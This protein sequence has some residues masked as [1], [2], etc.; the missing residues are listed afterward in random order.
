VALESSA[1]VV[2]SHPS[3]ANTSLALLQRAQSR[4]TATPV[5]EAKN[6]SRGSSSQAKPPHQ[7]HAAFQQHHSMLSI[8]RHAV[9]GEASPPEG[10][11]RDDLKPHVKSEIGWLEAIWINSGVVGIAL[12]AIEGAAMSA[13]EGTCL[14]VII[15]SCLILTVRW[16]VAGEEMLLR[17]SSSSSGR[18]KFPA[19]VSKADA[20]FTACDCNKDGRLSYEEFSWLAQRSGRKFSMKSYRDLCRSLDADSQGLTIKEFRQSYATLGHD[21]EY[22]FAIVERALRDGTG[23]ETAVIIDTAVAKKGNTRSCRLSLGSPGFS[24]G[25]TASVGSLIQNLLTFM[26]LR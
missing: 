25:T 9:P 21:V 15:V 18:D 8:D 24:S 16:C 12:T 17:P 6:S 11:D 13:F 20:V 7:K 3:H 4:E 10:R 2:I 23:P 14:L 5:K 22:D 19:W 1:G 26:R